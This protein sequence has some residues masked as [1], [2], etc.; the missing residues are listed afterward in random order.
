MG[1]RRFCLGLLQGSGVALLLFAAFC[2]LLFLR[3]PGC[4]SCMGTGGFIQ[5]KDRGICP[6]C[7]GSGLGRHL[8][9]HLYR[10]T[11]FCVG[12]ED[13][14]WRL[15]VARQGVNLWESNLLILPA[16][17]WLGA[18]VAALIGL[19]MGLRGGDC[20]LCDSR[21]TLLLEVEPPGRPP[22]CRTVACPACEGKG[23]LTRL[24][25]WLAGV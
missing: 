6:D 8:N 13:G 19:I 21:G 22:K 11:G 2:G 3:G 17:T 25:R 16:L 23:R 4:W 5:G 10:T 15:I 12:Q 20:P 14:P 18:G 24:D 7:E 1:R 9:I